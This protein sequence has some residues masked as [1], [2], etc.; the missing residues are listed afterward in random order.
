[1]RHELVELAGTA[2]AT[3]LRSSKHVRLYGAVTLGVAL[4]VAYLVLAAQGTQTSYQLAQLQNQQAQL[5]AEQAQLQ[6]AE[7]DLHTPAR[8][9]QSAQQAGLRR[10]NAAGYVGGQVAAID[11]GAPIGQS[12]AGSE[13]LWQRAVAAVI[14]TVT[15]TKDVLASSGTH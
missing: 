2:A 12:A 7:A 9:D 3:R 6:Y 8:V 5:Q 10:N 15:G 13:P 14:G 11:L 1:M 4:L